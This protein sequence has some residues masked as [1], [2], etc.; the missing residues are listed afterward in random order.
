MM[1]FLGRTSRMM[2]L[3]IEVEGAVAGLIQFGEEQTP[4]YRHATIEQYVVDDRNMATVEHVVEQLEGEPDG[5]AERARA[6]GPPPTS[7][8]SSQAAA[9]RRA[10]FSSQRLQVALERDVRA[11]RVGALHQLAAG[12]RRRGRR[13]RAQLRDRAVAREL[14]EGARE[15]QVAGRGRRVAAGRRVDGAAPAPQRRVVED[16]VV[17]ERRRVDQLDGGGGARELDAARR[18]RARRRTPAAGAAA[19]RPPRPSPASARRSP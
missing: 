2:R 9:N 10:V 13:E 17:D 4:K 3:T 19:C 18:C 8:P 11:P 15:Q 5:V 6:A 1:D 16:V 14:G 12:E 7:A